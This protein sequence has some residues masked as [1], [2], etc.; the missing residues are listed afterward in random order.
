[1]IYVELWVQIHDLSLGL[2]SEAMV[3]QF[4]SFPDVRLLLKRKK[5]IVLG[6]SRTVYARFK[7]EKLSLFCFLCGKLGHGESF[8]PVRVRIDLAKI[9]FGWD[10]SLRALVRRRPSL[11]SRWLRKPDETVSQRLDKNRS[12][13]GCNF[14]DNVMDFYPNRNQNFIRS[15]RFQSVKAKER[16]SNWENNLNINEPNDS[17]LIKLG[18]DGE[19]CPIQFVDK[20]KRQRTLGVTSV[21]LFNGDV[22]VVGEGQD[23]S[24]SSTMQGGERNENP[25][26]GCL[27]ARKTM[28][29]KSSQE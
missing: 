17:R 27:W 26:L 7:Y 1:M 20:K 15:I 5:K 10:I 16:V 28:G 21:D 18:S 12:M 23:R 19:E 8:F 24:A 22:E 6:A 25:K 29:Y 2:M 14:W 11:V 13:N 9:I 4:G 3:Q